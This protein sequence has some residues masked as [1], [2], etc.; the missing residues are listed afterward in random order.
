MFDDGVCLR[1]G[2]F[3]AEL[4]PGAAAHFHPDDARRLGL[5]EESMVD[6]KTSSGSARLPVRIDESLMH[7][8]VYVPF[9]QPGTPSLGSDPI[10]TVTKV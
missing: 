9:N 10:V 1:H 6:L 8:V 4:T 2:L 3:L 5:K 7:G